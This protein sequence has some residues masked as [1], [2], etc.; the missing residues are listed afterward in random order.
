[1]ALRVSDAPDLPTL[2]AMSTI[3]LTTKYP[4]IAFLLALFPAQMSLDGGPPQ[5]VGWGTTDIPVSPGQHSLVVWV[6][7]LGFWNIGRAEASV[8]VAEGQTVAVN[9]KSPWL[10]FLP[11]KIETAPAA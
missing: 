2:G 5:K 3:R 11:G 4:W 6:P 7:Y 9:Y 8:D 1:M 10:V